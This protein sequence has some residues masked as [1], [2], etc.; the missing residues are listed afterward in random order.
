MKNSDYWKQRFTQ[1]EAAQNEMSLKSLSKIERMYKIAQR[2]IEKDIS[3]WYS[4][5][6][7]NNNIRLSE[8]RKLLSKDELAEFKWDVNE[9]IRR[10]QENALDGR[11]MKEL[12]NASAKY[13]ISR[14]EAL[15][16]N[17]ENSLQ[18]LTADLNG[19]VTTLFHETYQSSYYHTA[20]ELQ[21]GFRIGFDIGTVDQ[22]R[23][24]RV[25]AKPWAADGY[26]F[27]ERLWKNKQKLIGEVHNQLTQNL[28]TGGD[29]QKAINAI[30]KKLNASKNNAARLVMTESAYFSSLA[31][32]DCY[33]DLGVEEFEIVAT[34]DAH[35]SEI[36]R[37]M[38]GQH[39]PMKDFQAGVT[40]PPFH[41][42]CR[43]TTV[44]YFAENFG[45]VGMRAARD[46]DGKT[47]YVPADMTYKEWERTFV[48]GDKSNLEKSDLLLT[49][50]KN[51]DI[52][53]GQKL[54]AQSS[55]NISGYD[56]VEDPESIEKL[57]KYA[58]NNF[59]ITHIQGVDLLKNGNSAIEILE[60]VEALS[61]EYGV[62]FSRLSIVDYGDAKTIAETFIN[63]LR[64]N[65]QFINRPDALAEILNI[66]E[67]ESH[68]PKGCNN[69]AYVGQHEFYH[70][71]TQDLLNQPQ[72]KLKTEVLRAALPSVSGNG[73]G[74]IQEYVADLLAAKKISS[75]QQKLKSVILGFFR[76][77]GL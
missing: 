34:L 64:L 35:T 39:F 31:Q 14:L 26:N 65:S 24:D 12:E 29:P 23:I 70:L 28:L 16:I 11:W 49:N 72:S 69:T 32:G 67:N 38:D 50:T 17:V 58:A 74:S 9:Y 18:S 5:I 60:S 41:P 33:R 46:E 22:S 76:K 48:D 13:H 68:I 66:W 42:W 43:S 40:A 52:I 57:K 1:L 77:E 36:C 62:N 27:S 19:A 20:F 61:K 10:G 15:K 30:T 3:R 47:Y 51:G 53:K 59:N 45:V 25:L 63:E 7:K 73:R 71:L 6:A 2:E 44:P 4:R 54:A 37:E 56:I 75:K 21:R 8:A 55:F